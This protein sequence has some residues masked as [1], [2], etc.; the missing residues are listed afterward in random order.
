MYLYPVSISRK[1]LLAR[2]FFALIVFSTWELHEL[3]PKNYICCTNECCHKS[4]LSC[5]AFSLFFK[6]G[7]NVVKRCFPTLAGERVA[8]A[9]C[10]FR[11][12]RPVGPEKLEGSV[13][14]CSRGWCGVT[15][16]HTFDVAKIRVLVGLNCNNCGL[17][18]SGVL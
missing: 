10:P 13:G 6:G 8:E 16:F 7:L 14:A 15:L 12:R 11:A 2:H 4:P 18:W 5:L 17:S 3:L 9:D 1:L